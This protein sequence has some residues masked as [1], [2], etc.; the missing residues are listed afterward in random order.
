MLER[1]PALRKLLEGRWPE[2]GRFFERAGPDLAGPPG[3]G[4]RGLFASVPRRLGKAASSTLEWPPSSPLPL[5]SRPH[6]TLTDYVRLWL[7]LEGL[8]QVASA[9]Q[10]GWLLQLYEAGEMGEQISI[11]R[12]LPFL[13]D[14]ARFLETGVQACRTNARDVFEAIVCENPFPGEYFPALNFNQAIMKAL[15]ME[16]R[17]GRVERLAERITPELTRMAAAYASERRAAGRSVP[18][19]AERLAQYGVQ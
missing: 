19:D 12:M 8:S 13:P 6:H 18:E 4:F 14:P 3:L 16:V 15:F 9:E 2:S 17:L 5:P 1:E 10:A 7:I 11:L